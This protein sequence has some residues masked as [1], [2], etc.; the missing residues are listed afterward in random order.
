MSSRIR[1]VLSP[2]GA[3][4]RVRP[5]L[6]CGLLLLSGRVCAARQVAPRDARPD[7][8]RRAAEVL[9]RLPAQLKA[10]DEAA[11]RV[12]LRL[13]AATFLFEQ[14][15]AGVGRDAVSLAADALADLHEH[16]AEVPRLYSDMYRRQ[17]LTLLQKHDPELAARL[18]ERYKLEVD[19]HHAAYDMLKDEAR[20]GRAVEIMRA[21][22]GRGQIPPTI[23]FFLAKLVEVKP[24]E[25]GRLLG[26]ILVAEDRQPGML[27]W[28][29]MFF[30]KHWFVHEKTPPEVQARYLT[31][32][33]NKA[34][35]AQGS[36]QDSELAYRLLNATLPLMQK[37][38]PA[39]YAQA[40][41]L[42]ANMSSASSI[43]LAERD[44]AAKRIEQSDDPL[45]QMIVEAEATKDASY[46]ERLLTD[47][48]QSALTKGRLQFAL[49]VVLK[50]SSE[51]KDF[52]LWRDR[53]FD[54]VLD[55]ALKDGDLAVAER[56]VSLTHAPL[57]RATG[58]QKLALHFHRANDPA[59]ALRLL[60]DALKLI[61]SA[62]HGP[63]KATAM[64][65]A[66]PLSLRVDGPGALALAQKAVKA[67]NELPRP[68]A[69]DAP[70]SEAHKLYVHQTIM[71]LAWFAVPVFRALAEADEQGALAAA[72]AINS[73]AL[74]ASAVFGAATGARAASAP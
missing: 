34:R 38:R 13:Q 55:R 33:V 17:V 62:P 8:R 50:V 57:A 56:A 67:I 71:P 59:R 27:N 12:F 36:P 43:S 11:V 2:A 10:V 58:T 63:E 51:E 31:L 53:F 61:E 37:L 66:V 19:D 45:G 72:D 15:P 73:R 60:A 48:A 70:G 30:L 28:D 29:L 4:P 23:D 39:L 32:L 22:V 49:D 3:G 54:N 20:V 69:A 46:R 26:D 5:A 21:S 16:E 44:E 35:A 18:A 14:D 7:A 47:A 24:E 25:V 40:A 9:S 6:I 52:L 1:K 68:R 64:L 65:K 42:V 41:A 74:R